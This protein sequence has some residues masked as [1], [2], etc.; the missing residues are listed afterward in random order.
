MKLQ[1]PPYGVQVIPL[2]SA[3]CRYITSQA[4]LDSPISAGID[5]GSIMTAQLSRLIGLAALRLESSLSEAALRAA[6]ALCDFGAEEGWRTGCLTA[7]AAVAAG[8]NRVNTMVLAARSCADLLRLGGRGVFGCM[9]E[10]TLTLL[11]GAAI[12]NRPPPEVSAGVACITGRQSWVSLDSW[13]LHAAMAAVSHTG[14]ETVFQGPQLLANL[15]RSA[16]VAAVLWCAPLPQSLWRS[17]SACGLVSLRLRTPPASSRIS[18]ASVKCQM[19]LCQIANASVQTL[20]SA[21]VCR[22]LLCSV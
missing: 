13:S 2:V 10:V 21:S 18:F 5:S 1:I 8:S 22:K 12:H 17:A 16:V 11:E 15:H 6:G 9:V 7:A 14:G 4:A 19:H 3:Q 20:S